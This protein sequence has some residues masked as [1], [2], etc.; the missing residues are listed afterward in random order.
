MIT[1]YDVLLVNT[2][3]GLNVKEKVAFSFKY[4]FIHPFGGKECAL[5]L[6]G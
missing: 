2:A 5:Y 6:S 3:G 1:T 4:L